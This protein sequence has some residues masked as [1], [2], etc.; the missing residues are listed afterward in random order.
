MGNDR[1]VTRSRNI[2]D[3]SVIAGGAVVTEKSEVMVLARVLDSCVRPAD[4]R[5]AGTL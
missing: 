5:C 2:L 3:I 4:G 1:K